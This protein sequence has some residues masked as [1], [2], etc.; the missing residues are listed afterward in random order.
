MSTYG[1][2]IYGQA[3]YGD[4]PAPVEYS[5]H[6]GFTKSHPVKKVSRDDVESAVRRAF[7]IAE[8]KNPD[9]II[10]VLEEIQTKRESINVDLA[11]YYDD[12]IRKVSDLINR[13]QLEIQANEF[14]K[15]QDELDDEE[16]LLML[17]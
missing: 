7:D 10:P 14:K 12:A 6:G 13:I 11:P 3:H 8:G 17:L 2:A 9:A 5:T 15:I 4:E 1:S 16:S